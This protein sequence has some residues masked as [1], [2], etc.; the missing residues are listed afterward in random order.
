MNKALR[1]WL[2]AIAVV[3]AIV[4]V[5]IIIANYLFDTGTKSCKNTC[6]KLGYTFG[7]YVKE[8]LTASCWCLKNGEPIRV[9]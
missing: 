9:F 5:A 4:L 2:I 1:D 7:W 3:V 6:E 8:Y